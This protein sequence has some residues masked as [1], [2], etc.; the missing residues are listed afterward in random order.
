MGRTRSCGSRRR[1]V[2]NTRLK[3]PLWHTTVAAAESSV[4]R[5][6]ESSVG[7]K[8]SLSRRVPSVAEVCSLEKREV[9]AAFQMIPIQKVRISAVLSRAALHSGTIPRERRSI[10]P[11]QESNSTRAE[12]P[13]RVWFSLCRP[14]QI[15]TALRF[16]EAGNYYPY[17]YVDE[18]W[19]D[20]AASFSEL[21]YVYGPIWTVESSNALEHVSC[22][23]SRT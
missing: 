5:S 8:W 23:F 13:S 1:V 4:E 17:V 6:V 22:G 11:R 9:S 19:S 10:I 7:K 12:N 2:E 15:S 18:F 16:D 21:R 14:A 20:H 3:V